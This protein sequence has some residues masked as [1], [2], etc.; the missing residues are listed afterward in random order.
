[1]LLAIPMH[2]LTLAVVLVSRCT[3]QTGRNVSGLHEADSNP[4]SSRFCDTIYLVDGIGQIREAVIWTAP[5]LP[6]KYSA[7]TM[8][9][10]ENW[11]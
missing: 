1:M 11:Q 6:H 8:G 9:S 2:A 3:H 10:V 4:K 7:E 5:S